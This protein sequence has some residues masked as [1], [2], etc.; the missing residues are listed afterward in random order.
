[1]DFKK[2]PDTDFRDVDELNTAQAREEVDALREGIEYHNYRYY[3]KNAPEISDARFDKLFDRLQQ[4]EGA[5]PELCSDSSPTRRVGAEPVDAL[6]KADH[7]APMLSLNAGREAADFD[8]FDDFVRRRSGGDE[9]E[10]VLE[11]KFD[12]FSV[13][14][15]YGDGVFKTGSTRGNGETGED[16]SHN[17]KTIGS[18]PLQLQHKSGAPDFLSVRG[19]VFMK[20]KGFQELNR[21]RIEKGQAPFANP[22]N[23]AAGTM[24]Q[25][26]PGSVAGR[27]LD[28]FF[29]DILKIKGDEVSSHWKALKGLRRWG[30]KTNPEA[31]KVSSRKAVREY[32]RRLCEKR[33]DLAYEIDG[34]VV[35]LDDYGLRDRLGTRQRSPRWAM[36]WKFEPQQEVTRLEKIVVQVGRTGKLT[37]V[38]LLQPVEVGGVT[39]SRASLHNADN[40]RQKDVRPGDTVR[41]ARAGDVIPEVVERIKKP[42]RK[43][44]PPFSMPSKCPACDSGIYREGAYHIC[45][46][47]LACRPQLTGRIRHYASREALDITGLGEKTISALVEAELVRDIA[48][49]YR[50]SR[51]DILTLDGFARKS[52]ARLHEAIQGSRKPRLD[53]FLYALGIRHVGRRTARTLALRFHGLERL[54]SAGKGELEKVPE[55]GSKIAQSV[56]LFFRQEKNRRVL[57]RLEEAGLRLRQPS[58]GERELPLEGKT[59]VFTGRLEGYTRREAEDLVASL[60]ARAASSVSGR[61]DYVVA[62]ENPGQKLQDAEENEVD[63][64]GENE[65]QELV[66]RSADADSST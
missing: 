31:K 9:V 32:H 22:R 64:I 1:M 40:V 36:A 20:K 26:D 34:I 6:E 53:R 24:R 49:L 19:E 66:N 8:R 61:T 17:L 12:G 13:E 54:A 38:A 63:I 4:L 46:G 52:A 15:V 51:A 47:G 48:D 59:F 10:Y 33:E 58:P 14:I 2:N 41:V 50:L 56:S 23:A 5:F 37:P 7:A 18:V 3:V 35:K 44:Q 45:P 39:V 55:V 57:E 29:Y 21:E 65:F 42:G 43:R 30:L 16:I 62:G 11:P 25:L 60:G 27:P 28:I